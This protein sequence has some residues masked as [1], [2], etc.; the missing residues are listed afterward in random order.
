MSDNNTPT[1][2][3]STLPS[4]KEYYVL[5]TGG[6]WDDGTINIDELATKVYGKQY[7]AIWGLEEDY[8]NG[9]LIEFMFADDEDEYQNCLDSFDLTEVSIGVD[10][11]TFRSVI[12]KGISPLEYWLSIS[13][14]DDPDK[15]N[16]E[17]NP[18]GVV[19]LEN[20]VFEN[21][22]YAARVHTLPLN[23][24]IAD[25]IRRGELPKAN[26]LFRNSW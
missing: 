19:D 20:A 14:S 16:I 2:K 3:S 13:W 17:A 5:G 8:P 11:N 25:L 18:R 22:H 1:T 7:N 21:E 24:V 26:Y 15:V 9:T 4:P 10:P 12:K 6:H 23:L